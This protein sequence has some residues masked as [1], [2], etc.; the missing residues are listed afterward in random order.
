MAPGTSAQAKQ[1]ETA[2]DVAEIPDEVAETQDEVAETEAIDS[3][4]NPVAAFEV[5]EDSDSEEQ[6]HVESISVEPS[7]PF[8]AV[9]DSSDDNAA[10]TVIIFY[11]YD[12]LRFTE[13]Y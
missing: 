4:K 11:L 9:S 3:Q 12:P 6:G 13:F 10:P 8:E 7:L 5:Q 2:D 1:V